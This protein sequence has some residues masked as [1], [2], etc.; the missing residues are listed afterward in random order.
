MNALRWTIGL[1]TA[2]ILAAWVALSVVGDNFRRSFGA[3]EG[4]PLPLIVGVASASLVLASV[5][6]PERRMLLHIV[7]VVMLALC[8]GCAFLARQTMF[9]ASLGFIYAALWFTFYYRVVWAAVRV[10]SPQP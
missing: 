4:S 1:T 7:A 5:V 9:V 2:L 3:S 8:V 10:A 6:W